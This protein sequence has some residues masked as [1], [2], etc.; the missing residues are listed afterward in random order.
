VGRWKEWSL[1]TKV[2]IILVIA[3]VAGLSGTVITATNLPMRGWLSFHVYRSIA[4]NTQRQYFGLNGVRL[5]YETYGRGSPVLVLHGGLG[6]I[7]DM[8]YQ[9]RALA[10][11]HFIVAPDSRGHGRSADANAPL[12]YSLMSDDVL[13]LV[14]HLNLQRVDVVG[15]SDGAIIGLDLAMRHPE[16]VRRLVAISANFDV[17]GL[18]ASPEATD[19]VDAQVPRA[20]LRYRMLAPDPAHWPAIYRKVVEMWH[21]QPQY[22]VD[23]LG[24]IEA[25]TLV[26]AGEFDIIK[27][28]HTDQLA[29]AISDSQE[30]IIKGAGHNVPL[31]KPKIVNSAILHFLGD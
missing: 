3:F 24:H 8:R 11:S 31:E 6:S 5:Y 4:G 28:D 16:R 10:K 12:S 18:A 26:V 7:E 21:T 9:I 17:E 19:P 2:T 29:K 27:R 30:I 23:D 20:P 1:L 14:D 25:P 22:T 13:R 15:W